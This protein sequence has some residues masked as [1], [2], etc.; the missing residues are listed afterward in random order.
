M[1]I[2]AIDPGTTKSGYVLWNPI[3]NIFIDKGKKD[4]DVL[5]TQLYLSPADIVLIENVSC[6]G[7]VVGNTIIETILWAGRFYQY[8]YA[9]M[10]KN[11][12][13][14][15][16]HLI[17]RKDVK[18]HH[19]AKNDKNIRDVLIMKY[20]KPGTK[21]KQGITYGLAND[22]WAAFALATYYSERNGF[23]KPIKR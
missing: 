21:D 19:R 13:P 16:L 2:L 8:F 3:N 17:T 14:E 9:K 12:S 4:N 23:Y 18:K 6:Y 10:G 22:M 1:K 20:G 15:E 5:L 11:I 7:Q